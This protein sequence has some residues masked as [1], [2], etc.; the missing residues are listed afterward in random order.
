MGVDE[1]TELES[2]AMTADTNHVQTVDFLAQALEKIS[3][4]DN[5]PDCRLSFDPDDYPL[6]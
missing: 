1:T 3:R 5:K 2:T 4:F 6:A